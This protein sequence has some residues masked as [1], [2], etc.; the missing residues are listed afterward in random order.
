MPGPGK[1]GGSPAVRER[2][3]D[4]LLVVLVLLVAALAYWFLRS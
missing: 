3:K 1:S 4:V 2:V